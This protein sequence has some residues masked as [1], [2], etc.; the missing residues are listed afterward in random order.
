MQAG[1]AVTPVHIDRNGIIIND[2]RSITVRQNTPDGP[3]RV[4]WIALGGGSYQVRFDKNGTP[5]DTNAIDVSPTSDVMSV[6]PG[7][8][9]KD[10]YRYSV[11]EG[12]R[13]TDDPDVVVV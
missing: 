11:Y 6:R 2:H 7:A 1:V 5:F 4:I 12:D 10:P 8:A 13:R 9:R 3:D